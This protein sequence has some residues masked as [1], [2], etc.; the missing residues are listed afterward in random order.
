MKSMG[1]AKNNRR[2]ARPGMAGSER[3]SSEVALQARAQLAR[4][5]EGATA[6]TSKRRAFSLSR[7]QD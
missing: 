7:Y 6:F 1:A 4:N 5:L 2:K 3:R